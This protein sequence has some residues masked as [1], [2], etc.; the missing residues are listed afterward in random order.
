MY[1][2]NEILDKKEQIN[3]LGFYPNLISPNCKFLSD[4]IKMNHAEI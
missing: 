3:Y 2:T 4:R 1:Q